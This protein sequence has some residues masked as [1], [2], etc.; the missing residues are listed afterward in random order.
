MKV[1]VVEAAARKQIVAPAP[2]FKKKGLADA[3]VEAMLFCQFG[4]R[5]CSSNSGMGLKL[6]KRS[7]SE[8]VQKQLGREWNPH[9]ASDIAISY[10]NFVEELEKQL[11]RKRRRPGRGETLVY[12]MLTDGFSTVLVENGTTRAVLDLLLEHTDYRIRVLTKN[13]VV[14][15]KR[16]V[17]YFATHRDRFVIG[18]STGSLDPNVTKSLE[19]GT[20]KPGKRIQGLRALQDADVPTFGMLCPVFPS[21]METDELE[22]LVDAIR[23]DRCEQVWSEVYNERHNWRSVRDAFGKRSSSYRW[24]TEVYEDGRMD[25]WSGYAVKLYQRLIAKARADGWADKL[26]YLLYEEHVTD[27]DAEA[28]AGLGCVS[29]QSRADKDSRFSRHSEFARLQQAS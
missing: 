5:Y 13:A 20:S 4:C 26:I 17:E 21:A 27:S 23:P 16:W 19:R 28:F 9:D 10:E 11:Q 22:R 8:I 24:M 14:G 3:H 15:Q 18:L 2:G 7:N 25:Q 12:S 6:R 1:N 29:L